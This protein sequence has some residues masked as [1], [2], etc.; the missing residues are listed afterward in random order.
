M[1]SKKRVICLNDLVDGITKD[2]AYEVKCIHYGQTVYYEIID[3]F[4]VVHTCGSSEFID[5]KQVVI[6]GG[7]NCTGLLTPYWMIEYFKRKGK[8]LYVYDWNCDEKNVSYYELI[9]TNNCKEF[10]KIYHI[11]YSYKKIEGRIL[12]SNDLIDEYSLF[13][14]ISREDKD[15]IDIVKEINN[16]KVIKIVDIPFDVDYYIEE[17]QCGFAETICEK[18][19]KWY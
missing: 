15:L 5:T 18:H 7:D 13:D 16:K 8:E 9:D 12:D 1:E 3:D 17:G 4:G 2:K 19:R 6:T 10:K 14:E 11:S